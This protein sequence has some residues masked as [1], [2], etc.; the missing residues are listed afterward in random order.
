MERRKMKLKEYLIG[1][2]TYIVAVIAISYGVYFGDI[3]AILLGLGIAGIRNGI[4][5]EIAVMV[6]K[7]RNK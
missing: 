4:T 1:K 7:K 5:S 6:V 3:Q 2:K